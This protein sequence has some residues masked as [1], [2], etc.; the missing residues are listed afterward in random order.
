M[1]E[2]YPFII[3]IINPFFNFLSARIKLVTNVDTYVI[4]FFIARIILFFIIFI[5]IIRYSDVVHAN[6]GNDDDAN[7]NDDGS[8]NID[9]DK[10]DKMCHNVSML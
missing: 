8:H 9:D 4:V 5:L 3:T 2:F 10:K 1:V 6:D 7:D